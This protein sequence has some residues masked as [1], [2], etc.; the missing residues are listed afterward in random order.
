MQSHKNILPFKA[1]VRKK[2]SLI[3]KQ[4]LGKEDNI[5]IYNAIQHAKSCIYPENL[6][7]HIRYRSFLEVLRHLFVVCIQLF[8]IL[9]LVIFRK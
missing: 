6:S 1:H 4:T 2:E 8:R 5:A 7:H 9:G 3:R